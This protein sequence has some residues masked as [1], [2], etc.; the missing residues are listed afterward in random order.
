MFRLHSLSHSSMQPSLSFC[1]SLFSIY[2]FLFFKVI[3][4]DL[5]TLILFLLF[6]RKSSSGEPGLMLYILSRDVHDLHLF[7]LTDSGRND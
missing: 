2:L 3:L 6:L 4:C 5:V 7:L 1:L